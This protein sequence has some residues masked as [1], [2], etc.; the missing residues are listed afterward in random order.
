LRIGLPPGRRERVVLLG[1]GAIGSV[2]ARELLNG[3]AGTLAGVLVRRPSTRDTIADISDRTWIG[4]RIDEALA[5]EPTLLVECAGH[6]A[7]FESVEPFLR[8]GVSALITSTGALADSLGRAALVEA[9]HA[10]NAEIRLSAGAIAGMD[11]LAALAVGGLVEVRY[12]CA[13]PPRAWLGT[14]AES[15]IDLN[16]CRE[17]V[18]FFE[19]NARDAAEQY[20]KNANIAATVAFT[21]LGLDATRVT[22]IADPTLTTN[23]GEVFAR[24]ATGT[25][26]A[27]LAGAVSPNPRT[28]AVTA[29]ALVREIRD[30]VAASRL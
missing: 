1:C 27:Q 3:A 15:L 2:V 22:L 14:A 20:P 19:G 29:H 5:L 17:R 8:A 10:G 25:L 12:T 23:V 7:V 21:G 4:T 9:A 6:H 11:G 16:A 18:V 26:K 30:G 28:S 24:G 13:K